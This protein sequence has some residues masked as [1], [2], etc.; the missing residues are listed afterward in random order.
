M[1]RI[2]LLFLNTIVWGLLLISGISGYRG[3]K[4]QDVPGYPNAD[5]LVLYVIIPAAIF[6]I[7]L[8]GIYVVRTARLRT[9]VG[10]IALLALL[11]ALPYVIISRGGV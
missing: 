5:Q 10:I 11:A 9:G 3:I 6:I 4:N 7:S 2:L 8:C 1:I